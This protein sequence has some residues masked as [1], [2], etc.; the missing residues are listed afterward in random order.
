MR[1]K[2]FIGLLLVGCLWLRAQDRYRTDRGEIHFNASTPLEDIDAVNQKASA[3]LVPE[4]GDFA[5]VLL[6]SEFNFRR[7][8]MQEHFNENYMESETY[9]KATFRGRIKELDIQALSAEKKEFPVQGS[10][11]IHGVTREIGTHATFTRQEDY[12]IMT[13]SLIIAPEDYGIKV[14]KL[15]FAKIARK[16]AVDVSFQLEPQ[17]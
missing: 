6:I 4:T 15:V 17:P 1:R 8:L 7:K 10:M 11:T 2:A 16:M 3:I 13:A 12:L 5:V 9:P 14:P